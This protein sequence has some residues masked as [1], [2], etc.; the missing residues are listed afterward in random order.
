VQN[1]WSRPP[2]GFVVEGFGEF[3]SYPSIVSR[4]LGNRS[5]H[6]PCV[7]AKGYGGVVKHLESHLE[8]LVRRS[9]PHRV[10]VTVDLRDVLKS[11]LGFEN[12]G[13]V[14]RSLTARA[15]QWLAVYGPAQGLGPL[16]HEVIIVVQVPQFETWLLSDPKRL[17]DM[18]SLPPDWPQEPVDLD[19]SIDNPAATLREVSGGRFNPKNPSVVKAFVGGIDTEAMRQ[20]SASF[21]KY[22]REVRRCH[23]EWLTAC[24]V[25]E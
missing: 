6:I 7:N 17:E 22:C 14:V 4:L 10:I 24:G 23:A 5:L 25:G 1:N 18:Y 21:A 13:H 15:R 20:W 8:D 12:C 19:Q 11:R 2:V 9:H 3:Y 16:P